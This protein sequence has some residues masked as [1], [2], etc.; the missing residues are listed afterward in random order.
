MKELD[1]SLPIFSNYLMTEIEILICPLNEI[2]KMGGRL[3]LS[4]PELISIKTGQE[5]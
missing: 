2:E 3:N 5:I 4:L 1:A